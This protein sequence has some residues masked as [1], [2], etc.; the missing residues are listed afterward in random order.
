MDSNKSRTG[1]LIGVAAAAGAFGVAAMMSTATAPTARADDFTEIIA[2]VND[3]FAI[4]QGELGD[5]FTDFGSGDPSDGLAQ[6]L[7]GV[8]TDV[9]GVPDSLVIGTAEA[10]SNE[11][12]GTGGTPIYPLSAPLTDFSDVLSVAQTEFSDGL[13]GFNDAATA[14]AGGDYGYA[15]EYF[16]DG[17]ND[18]SIY[19]VQELLLG[20]VASF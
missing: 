8:E 11:A 20:A 1:V 17:L 10:L 6:L 12:I 3:D 18:T 19:S 13:A 7:A 5:A 14:L 15:V 2:N 16:V 9:V 4:G